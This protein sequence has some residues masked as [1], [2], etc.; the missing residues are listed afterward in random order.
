MYFFERK[1]VMSFKK[2][3]GIDII[4]LQKRYGALKAI[5]EK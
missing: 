1:V 4:T 5:G 3:D 2:L